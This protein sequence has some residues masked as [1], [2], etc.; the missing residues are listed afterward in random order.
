MS[1][2]LDFGSEVDRTTPMATQ[3]VNKRPLNGIKRKPMRFSNL[4]SIPLAP[5]MSPFRNSFQINKAQ[6]KPCIMII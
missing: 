3:I 2:M 1:I 6:K 4:S 5:S